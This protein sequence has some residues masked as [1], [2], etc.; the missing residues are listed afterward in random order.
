MVYGLEAVYGQNDTFGDS[1]ASVWF[2]GSAREILM[3]FRGLLKRFFLAKMFGSEDS[4]FLKILS[5]LLWFYYRV[6][7]WY[8]NGFLGIFTRFTCCKG[9]VFI[10]CC[11]LNTII[12]ILVSLDFKINIA[13]TLCFMLLDGAAT[14]RGTTECRI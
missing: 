2:A 14:F 7:T 6:F 9:L 10:I 3:D 12:H 13:P 4:I 1:L 8:F 5:R 11:V